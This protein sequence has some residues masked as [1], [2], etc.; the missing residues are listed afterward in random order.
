MKMVLDRTGFSCLVIGCVICTVVVLD[1]CRMHLQRIMRIWLQCMEGIWCLEV[2]IPLLKGP[3]MEQHHSSKTN[4]E[5]GC[6][7]FEIMNICDVFER[8]RVMQN[9]PFWTFERE[10]L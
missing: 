4:W 5:T 1:Q 7:L 3:I 6:F 2:R 9:L 8:V 10:L